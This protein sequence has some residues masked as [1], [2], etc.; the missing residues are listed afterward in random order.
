M[1]SPKSKITRSRRGMRRSH[2]KASVPA[3]STCATTGDLTRPHRAHRADDGALYYKGKQISPS[4][5]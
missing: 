3:T 4:K 1:A 5:E 2:D